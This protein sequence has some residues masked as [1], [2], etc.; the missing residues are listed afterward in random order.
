M[1]IL[2]QVNIYTIPWHTTAASLLLLQRVVEVLGQSFR[3]VSDPVHCTLVMAGVNSEVLKKPPPIAVA[4]VENGIVHP[5]NLDCQSKL[6]VC[7]EI[8]MSHSSP[9]GENPTS[10]QTTEASLS[11]HESKQIVWYPPPLQISTLP[12]LRSSPM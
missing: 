8:C 7:C 1:K 6:N 3:E 2:R 4:P 9:L 10:L 11:S 5:Y 12:L